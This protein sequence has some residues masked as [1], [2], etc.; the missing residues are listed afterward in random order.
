MAL[1]LEPLPVPSDSTV[2]S[3][4]DD[5][6]DALAGRRALL[7]L[8]ADDPRRADL[9]RVTQRAGEPVDGAA[10]VVATSG[11]T[12][13]PKGALLP[14]GA[15]RASAAA[16]ARALGGEG[17]WLLA[18]PAHHIA[19]L[20]VLLRSLAAGT[21]PITMSLAS[22]FD[23][24]AF[25]EATG[26]LT[27]ARRYT[28]LTP[29]Q[30]LKAMDRLAGIEALRSFDAVLVGGAPLS[31]AARRAARDLGIT[32]RET[33]G[34]SETCGGCVYDGRP[35]PG[36]RVRIADDSRIV[37]AGDVLASGY[38]RGPSDAF[39]DGEF[40]T[41]D[42][43]TLAEDGTLS[44]LGRLDTVIVTGGLKLHPEVLER[45]LAE[46]PGVDEAC[47]VGVPHPRFGE[48][49]VAVYAGSAL[50]HELV[51]VTDDLPRWQQP[52]DIKRVERLPR[53]ALGKPDRDRII[54]DISKS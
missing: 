46:V 30:L 11:S 21:E 19:G 40:H 24:D 32:V 37:L 38:R 47:V 48:A 54:R 35:L 33:Y 6:A 29:M 52:K 5:L 17:Q 9:L 49:V 34:S 22:G 18:L 25:A 13:T 15:L 28:S 50:P 8:P 3:I 53:T 51:A 12:G 20:Q 42:A 43:G 16:T 39:R 14:P 23:I 7:P 44:V 41:S 27:G 31:R 1:P 4:L 2:T 36:V 10:L 26:R 45:R